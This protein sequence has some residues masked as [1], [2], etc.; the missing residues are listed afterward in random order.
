MVLSVV[1]ILFFY[2]IILKFCV[3]VDFKRVFVLR[4][5]KS[6]E[7]GVRSHLHHAEQ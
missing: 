1:T 3:A 4:F 2:T 7:L 6:D 5:Q